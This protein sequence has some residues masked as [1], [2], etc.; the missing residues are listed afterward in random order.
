MFIM[1][2][3]YRIINPTCGLAFGCSIFPTR[4]ISMGTA[5]LSEKE[6]MSGVMAPGNPAMPINRMK[7][8]I[9]ELGILG[10]LKSRSARISTFSSCMC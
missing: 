3:N 7:I 2:N 10:V 9:S 1:V 5:S 6:N 4:A 8:G